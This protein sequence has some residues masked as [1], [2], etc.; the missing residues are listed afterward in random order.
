MK[1][2]SIETQRE[3]VEALDK[4]TSELNAIRARDGA[5]QHI[6]WYQ[7]RPLQT[8]SVTHEYWEALTEQ[9]FAALKKARKEM[10]GDDG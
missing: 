5:P 3:L 10:G 7:G 8:S 1:P 6:D 4:A 9:C 2:I